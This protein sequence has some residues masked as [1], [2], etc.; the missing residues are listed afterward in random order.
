[1]GFFILALP[2]CAQAISFDLFSFTGDPS[3]VMVDITQPSA[4]DPIR[5]G[6]GSILIP[7]H[8]RCLETY[9]FTKVLIRLHPR[10]LYTEMM[11]HVI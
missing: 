4:T 6:F 2:L 9:L 11:F 5:G 8:R 1:M 7:S 3:L 10:V